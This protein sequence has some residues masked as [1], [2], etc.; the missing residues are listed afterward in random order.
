MKPPDAAGLAGSRLGVDFGGVIIPYDRARFITCSIE[1]VIHLEP[2]PGAVDAIAGLVEHSGGQVW[3][4]SKAGQETRRRT[5][6]WL[7]HHDFFG[8]IGL[9]RANIEFCDEHHEKRLL[10]QGFGITHMI[11]DRLEVLD[12][13]DGA[14]GERLLFGDRQGAGVLNHPG[15]TALR[16]WPA[17]MRHLLP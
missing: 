17:V 5:L 6:R 9:P 2:L 8:R 4:I 14:V 7:D 13:L 16:D 11:D 10:C 15:V 3:I 1:D 12:A